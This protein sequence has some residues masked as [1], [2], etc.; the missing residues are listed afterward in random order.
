MGPQQFQVTYLQHAKDL[1]RRTIQ[2]ATAAGLRA[3]AIR[4]AQ[5][6]ER[7]LLWCPEDLGEFRGTLRLLGE[8][9]WVAILPV[10]AWFA[11]HRER[12]QVWVSRF[13]FVPPHPRG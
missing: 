10:S 1:F 4:A 8:L 11:V 2:Q 6:I 13:R 12:R 3:E 9:R 7:G 5:A